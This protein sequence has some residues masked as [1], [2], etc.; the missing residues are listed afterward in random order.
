MTSFNAFRIHL[1]A[2]GEVRS[3]IESL[4]LDELSPGEVVIEVEYSAVNYKDALAGT[5]R[6]RILRQSPLIG[7]IDAVGAVIDGGATG[8]AAGQPVVV[9]GCGL[10]ETRDGGY[11]RYL[12]V[13]ADCVVPLPDTLT[14]FQAAALGTAGF[15]A[16]L[17]VQRMEDNS[18]TPAHGPILV[19]G[20]SGG[21]GS[22]AVDLLAGCGYEVHA[23]TGK[24]DR[25]GDWLR[26][27]G[28]AQVVDRHALDYGK[29]PLEK[30]LWGGAVDNAGGET[31]AWLTRTVR[32]YGN[33]AAIGLAGG[34]ELNTTVMPFI[35]RG[36]SLLGIHSVD[37][38]PAL[39][40]HVW[41]RL[42][43]DLRPRHLEAIVQETVDLE[44]LPRVFEQMLAGAVQGRVVVRVGV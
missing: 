31:L 6:G 4:H 34:V 36:V 18:Q 28:A 14:S 26:T 20:A 7:G 17:A 37:C 2:D 10:S 44:T 11:A 12:R 3:G 39:R 25:S 41:S 24:L 40:R 42:A 29:R 8:F 21:V 35:L 15:T 32:P 22:L 1:E 5:G 30:A 33:I 16:A 43:G 23:L 27:L 38:P 19:T 13:P 9:T